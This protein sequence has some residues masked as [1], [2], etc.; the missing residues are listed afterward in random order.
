MTE[1]LPAAQGW[2]SPKHRTHGT[3]KAAPRMPDLAQ[4]KS[5]RRRQDLG[6]AH[7]RSRF[8]PAPLST[9]KGETVQ[10]V[11]HRTAVSSKPESSSCCMLEADLDA[12][13]T[14][15]S[16]FFDEK[17]G[18]GPS[19]G[20]N[21]PLTMAMLKRIMTLQSMVDGLM[22]SLC[23]ETLKQ[24]FLVALTGTLRQP[25]LNALGYSGHS[26]DWRDLTSTPQRKSLQHGSA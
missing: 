22:S 2:S 11:E 21:A 4:S 8:A 19:Q 10:E 16:M 20:M 1:V 12:P 17:P 5:C 23:K 24:L 13:A 3:P 18:L 9:T 26:A 25:R 7:M 6:N 15:M 14:R